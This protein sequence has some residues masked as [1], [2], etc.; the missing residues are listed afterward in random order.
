MILLLLHLEEF[1]FYIFS[2]FKSQHLSWSKAMS[3]IIYLYGLRP[4]QSQHE[5]QGKSR[6]ILQTLGVD[7]SIFHT[8][9]V[10]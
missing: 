1:S 3:T 7:K 2:H 5:V 6:P 9:L 8:M 4:I 10:I